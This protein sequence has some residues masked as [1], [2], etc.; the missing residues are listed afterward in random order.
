MD[1]INYNQFYQ[2][3]GHII[4]NEKDLDQFVG[5]VYF[6]SKK[7]KNYSYRNDKPF[8]CLNGC[9]RKHK[10]GYSNFMKHLT[11]SF[12]YPD[13]K[14][15]RIFGCQRF[16]QLKSR[17]RLIEWVKEID[18]NFVYLERKRICPLCKYPVSNCL[19]DEH[20]QRCST[21]CNTYW[22]TSGENQHEY[23]GESQYALRFLLRPFVC[24][25]VKFKV[26]NEKFKNE[27]Y[28]PKMQK[29]IDDKKLRIT[30]VLD[31][32]DFNKASDLEGYIIHKFDSTNSTTNRQRSNQ[33][34][35]S[36][37]QTEMFESLMDST[38][39]QTITLN[40][41]NGLFNLMNSLFPK[42]EERIN[43]TFETKFK[44]RGKNRKKR[45]ISS[46]KLFNEMVNNCL[47]RL[48]FKIPELVKMTFKE[49][50]NYIIKFS[51]GPHTTCS[52][53]HNHPKVKIFID[54][55]DNDVISDITSFF[56]LSL[57]LLESASRAT[58]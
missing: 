9:K 6:N 25:L 48:Q 26:K 27:D 1:Q 57:S 41:L 12:H 56:S 39:H 47:V 31:K 16:N 58:R 45:Y 8:E 53:D 5:K 10:S 18:G 21:E 11:S 15:V 4:K 37:L 55:L 34:E 14:I 20:Y 30:K 43:G 52:S 40:L 23:V 19:F 13:D 3:D 44:K 42:F 2:I 38:Q 51:K 50:L 28:I 32:T 54:I 35:L 17:G 22:I 24:Y 36:D 29:L 46:F 49:Q 33:K 7:G